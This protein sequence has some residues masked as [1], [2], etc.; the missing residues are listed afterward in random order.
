MSFASDVKNEMCRI[1]PQQCCR[2]AECYGLLLCGRNFSAAGI[3]LTTETHAVALRAAEFAAQTAAAVM[4]VTSVELHKKNSGHSYTVCAAGVDETKKVLAFLGHSG[5]EISLRINLGNLE[6]ECCRA[7]FLRGAFLSCGTISDPGAEYR[8]EF[9]VPYMNLAKDLVGLIRDILEL[10][11]QPRMSRRRG[12]FVVYIKGG[13]KVPDFLAYLGAP[14][15][16][17]NMMQVRM[18]KELRNNV[19]RQTNFETANLGKTAAAAAQ[20]VLAIEKIRATCGIRA[21]PEELRGLA[22]L[23][24][25]NPEMSLRELGQSLSPPLSRSGVHHRLQRILEFGEKISEKKHP[26]FKERDR[27]AAAPQK[28]ESSGTGKPDGG[29]RVAEPAER[30]TPRRAASKKK[31]PS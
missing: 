13:E 31:T 22:A 3:S 29:Q 18:L 2:K 24:Y 5:S 14:S 19:N 12:S 8:L 15:A 6:N 27:A 20:E 7:S 25:H 16:A 1:E 23:R 17:M 30:R 11:L 4:D 21:L 10:D 28:W 26:E 9:S